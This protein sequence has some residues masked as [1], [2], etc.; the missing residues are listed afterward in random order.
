MNLYAKPQ[1]PLK[2]RIF[3][4]TFLGGFPWFSYGFTRVFPRVF[5]VKPA[6]F[7]RETVVKRARRLGRAGGRGP[8]VRGDLRAALVR[9][10]AGRRG[11]WDKYGLGQ[12]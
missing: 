10:G 6:V 3:P 1:N 9:W 7:T 11:S 5:Q 8:G 2:T 12:S 4:M